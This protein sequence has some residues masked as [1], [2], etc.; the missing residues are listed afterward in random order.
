M[1]FN[2]V[3]LLTVICTFLVMTRISV[4][5]VGDAS[6]LTRY[7]DVT[8]T[9]DL[10]HLSDNQ[11]EMIKLLIQAGQE[12]DDA[13]WYQAFGD[14]QTLLDSIPDEKMRRFAEINY[15]PWDRLGGDRPFLESFQSKAGWV[16]T[17]TRKT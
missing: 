7:T 4:A 3:A 10:S 6:T 12:M 8:L 16:P 1:K 15:G 14:K 11:R 9:T 5:Q 13:F 2:L 17:S